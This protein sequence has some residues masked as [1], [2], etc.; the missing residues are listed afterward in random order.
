M[1]EESQPMVHRDQEVHNFVI[2]GNKGS[3]SWV[4]R[5][6]RDWVLRVGSSTATVVVRYSIFLLFVGAFCLTTYFGP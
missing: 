4:S 3:K 6:G 5:I 2:G 1:L